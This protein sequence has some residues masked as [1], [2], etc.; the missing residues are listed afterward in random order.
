MSLPARLTILDH[1]LARIELAIL[2]STSSG[3]DAF[4]GSLNRLAGLLLMEATRHFETSEIPVTTPLRQTAGAALAR[5][6]V[7]VPILRAG[8]GLLDGVLHLLP[9]ATVAH[10]GI[11]RNEATAAPEPYYA[12]LPACL[13]EA[14]VVVLDPM[15]ATGGSAVEAL[16]QLKLAGATRLTLMTV[17]SC[18]EGLQNVGAAHPDVRLVTGAVDEGLDARNYIVPGLGDAGDRY[19]GT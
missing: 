18:P 1:P 2:R 15:L 8:L 14:E 16:R 11:A 7:L 5:P 13:P 17:V 10:V 9:G 19:F 3:T 6:V 12:K 4:R